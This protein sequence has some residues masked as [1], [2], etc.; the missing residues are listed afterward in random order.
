MIPAIYRVVEEPVRA[1]TVVGPHPEPRGVL[2]Q[3]V[4]QPAGEGGIVLPLPSFGGLPGWTRSRR[5]RPPGRD[6]ATGS[7]M[8]PNRHAH[9]TGEAKEC[10]FEGGSS[11]LLGTDDRVMVTTMRIAE[12]RRRSVSRISPGAGWL[13][14]FGPLSLTNAGGGRCGGY[15]RRRR[16]RAW[17]PRQLRRTRRSGACDHGG[18][19]GRGY[20]CLHSAAGRS[21]VR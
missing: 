19:I 6:P 18:R 14:D 9:R 3:V 2:T 17:S 10:L 16:C 13:R 20:R 15:Q 1:L 8:S 4:S 7:R 21:S 12:F 5:S 11:D